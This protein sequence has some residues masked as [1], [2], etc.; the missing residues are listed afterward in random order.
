[1][2]VRGSFQTAL[3]ASHFH[4][5]DALRAA[6]VL[7]LEHFHPMTPTQTVIYYREPASAVLIPSLLLAYALAFSI[8]AN[9][10]ESGGR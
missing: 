5:L 1:V 8:A 3:R 9:R 6:T 10:S 7:T 4:T 2:R